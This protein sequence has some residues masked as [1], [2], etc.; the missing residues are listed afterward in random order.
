M[1]KYVKYN[2]C[3]QRDDSEKYLFSWILQKYYQGYK[4]LLQIEVHHRGSIQTLLNN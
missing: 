4:N 1:L 3:Q 2:I